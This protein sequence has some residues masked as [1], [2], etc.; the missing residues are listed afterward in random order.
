VQAAG[1]FLVAASL[2]E[3]MQDFSITRRDFDGIQ[4]DH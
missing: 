3:Q 4:I 2:C 1:N